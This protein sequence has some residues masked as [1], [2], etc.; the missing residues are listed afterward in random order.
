ML[1]WHEGALEKFL[2]ER[3]EDQ[4]VEVDQA[5]EADSELTQLLA[6]W[7]QTARQGGRSVVL[8]GL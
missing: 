7:G 1:R 5:T 6:H 3:G 8:S 4:L 2:V